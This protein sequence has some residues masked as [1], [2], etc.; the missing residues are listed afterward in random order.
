[1][2]NHKS[3]VPEL[4]SI[5]LRAFFDGK[6]ERGNSEGDEQSARVILSSN[7]AREPSYAQAC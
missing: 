3:L 1:M 2:A 4:E 6:L 7:W 5:V